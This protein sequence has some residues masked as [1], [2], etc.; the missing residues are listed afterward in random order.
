M[1]HSWRACVGKHIS[2]VTSEP[3]DESTNNIGVTFDHWQGIYAFL[4]SGLAETFGWGSRIGFEYIC[5]LENLFKAF[6]EDKMWGKK[7]CWVLITI[8]FHFVPKLNRQKIKKCQAKNLTG[9]NHDHF[10]LCTKAEWA[11][12]EKNARQEICWKRLWLFRTK[13]EQAKYEKM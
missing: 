1:L 8:I 12:N 10:P 6:S 4:N 2:D 7:I 9:A 13:T 11:K 5:W 3:L